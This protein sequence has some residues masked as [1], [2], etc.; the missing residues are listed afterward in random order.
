MENV[1]IYQ[2]NIRLFAIISIILITI[3]Q[4]H[5]QTRQYVQKKNP[6]VRIKNSEF[7]TISSSDINDEYE[8][9]VSLPFGYEKS[10]TTYPVVY[11]LDADI[12]FGMTTDICRLLQIRNELPELVIVGIAYGAYPGQKGNNRERDYTPTT[13]LNKPN[14][15]GAPNFLDF[16]RSD[17]I[18][19]IESKYRVNPSKRTI[20][21]VSLGGSFGLYVVFQKHD[22]FQ[23]Y[24]ICS[25]SIWWDN[26][27]LLQL[28]KS[29]SESH[30]ELPIHLFLSVGELENQD[31][32]VIPWQELIKA[33]KSRNYSGLI[34]K[35]VMI[36]GETHLSAQ[37]AAIVRG[38]KFVFSND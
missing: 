5:A 14:S 11:C 31:N 33:I 38:L 8:I 25:P 18:P 1:M 15:G 16:V 30:S 34:M 2:I 19:K 36:D 3:S 10:D 28:E 12:G 17:L 32:M 24:I 35:S 37:P 22:I 9:Y 23:N 4:I 29:Y 6:E 13:V 7:F 26:K 27:K 21:G 20:I